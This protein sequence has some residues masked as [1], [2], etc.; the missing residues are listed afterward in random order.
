MIFLA[1]HSAERLPHA[2]HLSTSLG[3]S[4][5]IGM[6]CYRILGAWVGEIW[7][8]LCPEHFA[9]FF[10]LAIHCTKCVGEACHPNLSGAFGSTATLGGIYTCN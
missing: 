10:L 1:R 7:V 2:G 6:R 8:S 3:R 4:L 5:L 9:V